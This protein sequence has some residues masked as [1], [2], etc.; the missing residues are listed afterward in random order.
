LSENYQL[1]ICSGWQQCL[2]VWALY[3]FGYGVSV[4]VALVKEPT[5]SWKSWFSRFKR[6]YHT[7]RTAIPEARRLNT[8]KE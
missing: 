7:F 2:Y 1:T 3:R 5:Q 8:W 4:R 6:I